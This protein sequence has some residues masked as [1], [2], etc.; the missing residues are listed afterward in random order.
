VSPISVPPLSERSCGIRDVVNR[1]VY[2]ER[3]P[4][5]FGSMLYP[6][7]LALVRAM[8]SNA[9]IQQETTHGCIPGS[10]DFD[11]ASSTSSSEDPTVLGC[12][13]PR[14]RS[15]VKL[16]VAAV[17]CA[18]ALNLITCPAQA[19]S[20]RSTTDQASQ[21][22]S[23]SDRDDNDDDDDDDDDNDDDDDD[24]DDDDRGDALSNITVQSPE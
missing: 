17:L 22:D 15:S 10:T 7:Y 23:D 13:K 16:F 8:L 4:K 1:H 5:G 18:F 24:D 6:G 2:G 12:G 21:D 14:L 20:N 11:H 19:D 9:N 3:M